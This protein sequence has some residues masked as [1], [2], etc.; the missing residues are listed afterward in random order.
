MRENRHIGP[1]FHSIFVLALLSLPLPASAAVDVWVTANGGGAE[2]HRHREVRIVHDEATRGFLG[3][4]VVELSPE[5]RLH[6]GSDEERGVLVSKVV[7]DSP[8]A[9]SGLRVGDVI[10]AVE[11]EDVDSRRDLRRLV[12]GR[13]RGDEVEIAVLR[14]AERRSFDVTLDERAGMVVDLAPMV[15]VGEDGA[16]HFRFDPERWERF[17]ERMER[18]GESVGSEAEAAAE[19]AVEEVMRSLEDKKVEVEIERQLVERKQLE[20]QLEVLERQLER[21][22][23]QL[24]RMEDRLEDE[25]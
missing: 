20:R 3:V 2:Q 24:E 18:L 10:T 16:Y 5:L 25:R 4:E 12:G 6:Y 23:R 14:D 1:S 21:M 13:E 7:P 19:R 8:A 9:V 17:G 15:R 22:Q 11:D